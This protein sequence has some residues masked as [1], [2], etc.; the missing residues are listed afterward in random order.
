M[1]VLERGN[2]RT[3]REGVQDKCEEGIRGKQRSA[4]H[5]CSLSPAESQVLIVGS[6]VTHARS[7]PRHMEKYRQCTLSRGHCTSMSLRARGLE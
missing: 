3:T 6:C 2:A 7:L 4:E 5:D 1:S